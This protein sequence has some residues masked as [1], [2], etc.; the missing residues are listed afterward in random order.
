[1]PGRERERAERRE[2]DK[3]N[4]RVTDMKRDRVEV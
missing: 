4:E 1:M 3:L 2:G